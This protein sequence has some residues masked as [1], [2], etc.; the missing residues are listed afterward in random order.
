MF[1][2]LGD[3]GITAAARALN[4]TRS[5][6]DVAMGRAIAGDIGLKVSTVRARLGAREATATNLIAR[7]TASPK[8]IP[9]I[10]FAASGP[11]PSRGRGRGVSA[12]IGGVRKRY[13]HLFLAKMRS[14][15]VGVFGRTPQSRSRRGQRRS[16]PQLPIVERFGPS[17]A[18]AFHKNKSVGLARA[19]E[20]LPKNMVSELRFELRQLSAARR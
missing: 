6:V 5:N 4:K 18:R 15:H 20:Q 7:I 11:M 3:R 12:R 8:R 19:A 10:E 16:S 9:L 17:I 1:I 13:Q 14:G 2:A